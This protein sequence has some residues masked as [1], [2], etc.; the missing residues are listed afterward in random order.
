MQGFPESWLFNGAVYMILGQVGNSVP[1]PMAY[2]VAKALL[3]TL[4]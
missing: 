4:I 1:P 2:H 3:Q